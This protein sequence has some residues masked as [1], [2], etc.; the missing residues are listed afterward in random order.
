VTLA[1]VLLPVALMLA[2]T[3]A[4]LTLP[5]DSRARAAT[6][7]AGNPTVA[8]LAAVLFAGWALGTRCGYTGRQILKLTEESIAAVGMTLLVVGGGGGFARVLR[9]AGVAEAIGRA[10]TSLHLSPLVYGWLLSAFVRV[11]T[12]SATVA[13]TTASGLLVPVL[14]AHPELGPNQVALVIV[15]IGCG[16]LILSHLNDSGFWIVKDLLG[17]SVPQ[18]LRAWT[19]CETIIGVVGMLLSLLAYRLVAPG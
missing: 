2:A 7:F 1:A 18:T 17:L 6:A 11:A 4:E 19:T 9:D 3:L 10:G 14:A 13:I 8:L 12:G 15:A 16:S 5:A